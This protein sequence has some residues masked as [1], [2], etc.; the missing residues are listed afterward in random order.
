MQVSGIPGMPTYR[1]PIDC[2]RR[3]W[4]TD[5]IRGL[6]RGIFPNLAKVIPATS[7]SFAAYERLSALGLGVVESHSARSL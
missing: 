6:Y 5:G 7:I 4:A 1:D 3:T 2:L